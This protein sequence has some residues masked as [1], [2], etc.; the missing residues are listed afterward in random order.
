MAF[1]KA[2][3]SWDIRRPEP[4]DRRAGVRRT[5]RAVP[6]VGIRTTCRPGGCHRD[7]RDPCCARRKAGNQY[8]AN[9]HGWV[10]RSHC[11]RSRP[12]PCTT[13]RQYHRPDER[14]YRAERQAARVAEG[15]RAAT[16]PCGHSRKP[17]SSGPPGCLGPLPEGRGKDRR[18]TLVRRSCY[19]LRRLPPR[20]S[21]PRNYGGLAGSARS[22]LLKRRRGGR[23]FVRVS[24]IRLHGGTERRRRVSVGGGSIRPACWLRCGSGAPTGGRDRSRDHDTCAGSQEVDGDDP[25]RFPYHRGSGRPESRHEPGTTWRQR[26]RTGIDGRPREIYGKMLELLKEAVPGL[27]RVALPWNPASPFGTLFGER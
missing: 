13:G 23:R 6:G 8:V 17:G 3:G 27:T 26:H 7:F 11:R 21:R 2:F 20:L 16:Q 18:S 25:H 5:Q 10:D 14:L 1:A 12:G 22:R 9:R 19:L 4:H 15:G 24:R